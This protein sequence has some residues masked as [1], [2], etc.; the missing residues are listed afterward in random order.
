MATKMPD[1]A[2]KPDDGIAVIDKEDIQFKK[3]PMFNVVL[4][5]D[6]FT[7]MMFVTGVLTDIFGKS[8]EQAIQVMLQVHNQGKGVAGTYAR[9]VAETKMQQ[10]IDRARREEHPL[11]IKVEPV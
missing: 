2:H 5:N 7:P 11:Q 6:D 4:V 10:T 8:T 1:W 9:D 3:P